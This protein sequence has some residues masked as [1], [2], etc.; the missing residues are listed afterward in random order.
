MRKDGP[1]F[2]N[3]CSTSTTGC[4]GAGAHGIFVSGG[5]LFG[6]D[7]VIGVEA[8]TTVVDAAGMPV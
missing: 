8:G 7:I 2:S 5:E 4:E 1:A 3:A 6:A